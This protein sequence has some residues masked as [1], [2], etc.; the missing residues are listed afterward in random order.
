MNQI[1]LSQ[2]SVVEYAVK[3]SQVSRSRI[4]LPARSHKSKLS[5][6]KDTKK[7]SQRHRSR[8]YST[9]LVEYFYRR[10]APCP[11]S[12]ET[13]RHRRSTQRTTRGHAYLGLELRWAAGSCTLGWDHSLTLPGISGSH[14]RDHHAACLCWAAH[15]ARSELCWAG[16]A[17]QRV[18]SPSGFETSACR[19]FR[20]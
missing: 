2:I 7:R 1:L 10:Q 8:P 4:Q 9:V 19:R 16:V 3:Y 6:D 17:Q 12:Q 11:K 20:P 13:K 5:S 14:S 15:Q 18:K